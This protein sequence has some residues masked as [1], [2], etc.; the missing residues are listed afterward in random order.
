VSSTPPHAPPSPNALLPEERRVQAG[1]G[2]SFIEPKHLFQALTHRSYV[3]ERKH[4]SPEDNETFEFLG[5]SI[6]GL[7]AAKLLRE[8][9]PSAREGELTRR[10]ADLVCERTLAKLAE[11]IDLGPALRLG[12]GEER[13]GGRTK[14]RLLASAFEACV[15]AIMLDAGVETALARATSL[16]E[17]HVDSLEPGADDFKS[18]IQEH[19]QAIGRQTPRYEIVGHEGPEHARTFFVTILNDEGEL[20]RGAGRNRN[21]AE[22]CAAKMA[23]LQLLP[24]RTSEDVCRRAETKEQT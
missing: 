19:L 6:V 3:N 18:R 23:L 4:L 15:A 9:F 2:H 1:L 20:A 10:R 24:Q 12:R 11:Q 22:Q 14:S 13:S 8:K 5:D 17:P 7:A 16:L 21:E